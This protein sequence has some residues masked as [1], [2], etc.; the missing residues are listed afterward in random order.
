MGFRLGSI[1]QWPLKRLQDEG[2]G[3]FESWVLGEDG[4]WRGRRVE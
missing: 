2:I 3:C 4:E 1:F